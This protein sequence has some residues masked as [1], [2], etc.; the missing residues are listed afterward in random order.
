[1]STL[2]ELCGYILH[3]VELH[4]TS[5]CHVLI[6]VILILVGILLNLKIDFS[7]LRKLLFCTS[8]TLHLCYILGM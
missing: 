4:A 8:C 6:V 3:K 1:M 2:R 7:N 5:N